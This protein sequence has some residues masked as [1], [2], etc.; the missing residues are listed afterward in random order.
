MLIFIFFFFPQLSEIK[1]ELEKVNDPKMA[2]QLQLIE[3]SLKV[4]AFISDVPLEDFVRQT[5]VK[6]R[7]TQN[8][9]KSRERSFVRGFRSRQKHLSDNQN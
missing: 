6:F 8:S 7:Q 3:Q 5:I 9:F 2:Q 1:S 4:G